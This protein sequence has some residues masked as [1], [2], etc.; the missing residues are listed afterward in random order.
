MPK[1][2]TSRV[3]WSAGLAWPGFGSDGQDKPARAEVGWSDLMEVRPGSSAAAFAAGEEGA[4]FIH[5]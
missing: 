2:F 5:A 4:S 1:G 3:A